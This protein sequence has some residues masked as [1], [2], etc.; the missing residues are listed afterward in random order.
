MTPANKVLQTIL[1]LVAEDK[2][3]TTILVEVGRT[4]KMLLLGRGFGRMVN[5]IV[6][7]I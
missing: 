7:T 2:R 3:Q 5:N 4:E 6:I 1:F